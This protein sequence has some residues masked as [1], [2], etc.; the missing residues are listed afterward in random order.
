MPAENPA[1]HSRVIVLGLVITGLALLFVVRLVQ[2]QAVDGARYAQVVDQ[3]R[4]VTEIIQ[5]RRGRILDRS[6]TPIADT[7]GVN[8]GESSGTI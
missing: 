8:K 3:S 1:V 5:P 6:G 4:V 2:L 7:T